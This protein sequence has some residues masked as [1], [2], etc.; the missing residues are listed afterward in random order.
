M[1]KIPSR[2]QLNGNI[3]NSL[4]VKINLSLRMIR[5]SWILIS[6]RNLLTFP[7]FR[8][9]IIRMSNQHSS[10][11]LGLR[12]LSQ[13]RKWLERD[14]AYEARRAGRRDAASNKKT[15]AKPNIGT[16]G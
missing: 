3:F 1:F 14:R 4:F 8:S 11:D 5:V 6:G 16:A 13:E 9:H 7:I 2:T 12:Q 10:K 15:P